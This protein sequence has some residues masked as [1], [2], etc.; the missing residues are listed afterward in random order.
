MS[1]PAS[2]NVSEFGCLSCDGTGKDPEAPEDCAVCGG[3]GKYQ[4]IANAWGQP[5]V[6]SVHADT[7]EED[8]ARKLVCIDTFM[9]ETTLTVEGAEALMSRV[10]AVV[11]D[12]RHGDEAQA[13]REAL[14][15]GE[16]FLE[17]RRETMSARVFNC[18]RRDGLL[19]VE[20]VRAKSDA[21]LLAIS[22][23]GVAALA[24]VR[25]AC[26]TEERS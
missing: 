14:E 18:L 6:T 12:I 7:D 10:Y 20:Q 4:G 22:G 5:G 9:C 16:E 8:E 21:E 26:G 1:A 15:R 17:D 25:A 3:S 11:Q 23:L 2:W 24:E 19:T 13:H